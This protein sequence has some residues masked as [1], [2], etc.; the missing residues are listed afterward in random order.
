[1]GRI[2]GLLS[3]HVFLK[4]KSWKTALSLT[5]KRQKAAGQM[6]NTT[7]K[8]ERNAYSNSG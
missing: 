6:K 3:Q 1:V 5:K 2:K 8:K 4:K 7:D